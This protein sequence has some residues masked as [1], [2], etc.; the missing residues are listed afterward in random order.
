MSHVDGYIFPC[1]SCGDAAGQIDAVISSLSAS[2]VNFKAH[3]ASLSA[4]EL[5]ADAAKNGATYGMLWIDVEGS[6]YWSSSTTNN[7]NFIQEM[8]KE[9]VARGVS[10]GVYTSS[11]QWSAICGSSTALSSYPLW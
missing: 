11:S 6:Q 8:A 2:N 7:V 3:N 1:Y 5:S 9:G 4:E 10:M